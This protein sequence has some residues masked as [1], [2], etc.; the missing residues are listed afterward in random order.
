M[1][2]ERLEHPAVV[3]LC[4]W[5]SALAVTILVAS[6]LE[7]FAAFPSFGDKVP[8]RDLFIPPDIVRL[9]GWLGGALQWHVTFAWVLI[10]TGFVYTIYQTIT[11]NYQQV[12]F[13]RGD[14]RGVWPMARHYFGFGPRPPQRATYNPLQKLAYTTAIAAGGALVVTGLALYKPVQLSA[15][16]WAA[17]GL[18]LLRIWHFAA[19]SVLLA[20]IPGHLI[21][22][23]LHGWSNVASMWT[24][25]HQV[26]EAAPDRRQTLTGAIRQ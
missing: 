9:G 15:I 13:S 19:M 2:G 14:V 5:L 20:F 10:T 3:R 8:Q 7:V 4:H 18:R 17:G 21:M 1:R 12:L 6:G 24:G 22:V 26:S 23:A 25:S 11:G 16:V